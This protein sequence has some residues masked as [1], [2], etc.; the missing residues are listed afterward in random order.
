MLARRARFQ[1]QV[2]VHVPRRRVQDRAAQRGQSGGGV[3][4]RVEGL[5]LRDEP[6]FDMHYS[7]MEDFEEFYLSFGM[8]NTL[9]L[10]VFSI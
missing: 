3:D 8:H 5:L 7:F 4:G 2:P 9:T 6:R 1:R 10:L